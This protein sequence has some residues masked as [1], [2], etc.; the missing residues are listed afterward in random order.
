MI[1]GGTSAVSSSSSSQTNSLLNSQ[2][3]KSG[4]TPQVFDP[5]F[6]IKV[7]SPRLTPD[8][9]NSY[10]QELQK[11]KLNTIGTAPSGETV[12]MGV[13][14]ESSGMKKSA[15]GK[16]YILWQLSDLS[17]FKVK[18]LLFGDAA[19]AHWKIPVGYVVALTNAEKSVEFT[20][21]VVQSAVTLKINKS[22]QVLNVGPCPD[23]GI[24]RGTKKNGEPCTNYVNAA[25]TPVCS[26]HIDKEAKK[27]LANRSSFTSTVNARNTTFKPP[28]DPQPSGLITV[29]RPRSTQQMSS[30][31]Q[32]TTGDRATIAAKARNEQRANF[33]LEVEK[34][35]RSN[36]TIKTIPKPEV[37]ATTSF[38]KDFMEQKTKTDVIRN[39]VSRVGPPQL[40]RSV[41]HANL[42]S[43]TSPKKIETKPQF[44]KAEDVAR[45]KAAEIFKKSLDSNGKPVKRKAPSDDQEGEKKCRLNA[46]KFSNNQIR[47]LLNKKSTHDFEVTR[48]KT[49]HEEKYFKQKEFEEKIETH[50]TT[51]MEVKE[52]SVVTC[53]TCSYT[54]MHLAQRCIDLNHDFVRHKATKRFF[55]CKECQTR[56]MC[57]GLMPTK[58]CIQCSSRDFER[59]AMKD[60]RK[61]EIREKLLVRGE[62]RTF[63]NK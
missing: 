27:L 7:S 28:T 25:F 8:T 33:K 47:A 6:G 42:I 57:F 14:V 22:L 12:T 19:S 44:S 41:Q 17:D 32:Y 60:E 38:L 2:E 9:F 40:G 55:K 3:K 26:F 51:L 23:F 24:C 5:F 61:V 11:V 13:I 53:K 45:K 49:E 48:A 46:S 15:N 58:P 43:L 63:V 37:K 4:S 35:N 31:V 56:T 30:R 59:V 34:E 1:I 52:V 54:T 62:E 29:N 20:G 36:S 10:C 16:E 39:A 50:A 18:V 21:T